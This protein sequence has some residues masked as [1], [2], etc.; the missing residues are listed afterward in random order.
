MNPETDRLL[1]LFLERANCENDDAFTRLASQLGYLKGLLDIL[2]LRSPEFA[3]L[4]QN[5]LTDKTET[6]T[7]TK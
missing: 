7:E 6:E 2:C 1:T 3:A 4:L 5:I